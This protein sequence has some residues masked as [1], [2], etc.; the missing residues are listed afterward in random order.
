MKFFITG[1]AGYIGAHLGDALLRHGHKVRIYDD[2]SSGL[3][4]RC[5]NR[6]FDIIE[7]DILDNEKLR[8]SMNDIDVVI[9][10]AAKKAVGESVIKPDFYFE[11]NV[12]GSKNILESMKFNSINKIIFSST[13]AVYSPKGNLLIDENCELNPL[14]PYGQNK[15]MVEDE[16]TNYCINSGFSA[17]TLRYFNVVGCG[18]LLLSDNSQENLVPKV[19]AAID[20]NESPLIF[21]DTYPTPDGTCIRDYVHI[22][23]LVEAHIKLLDHFIKGENQIFNIGS[24]SGYSVKQV[25]YEIRETVGFALNE[26]VVEVRAGDTAKLVANISKIK[27]MVNWTPKESLSSMVK[28]AWAGW[29]LNRE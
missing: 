23:D 29:Q 20:S 19:F 4:R 21:G 3:K 27:N 12:I 5:E 28:S 22:S 7:G 6:F 17:I 11:N 2:F 16:I 14:S 15:L 13:A 25:M 10:L 1:G 8:S 24:G 9:H 18:D 26:K